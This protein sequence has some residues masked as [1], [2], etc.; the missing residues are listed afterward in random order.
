MSQIIQ[1]YTIVIIHKSPSNRISTNN[2]GLSKQAKV[3]DFMQTM[4]ASQSQNVGVHA[5]K[6]TIYISYSLHPKFCWKITSIWLISE[7]Q[8]PAF[9]GRSD[10]MLS[11]AKAPETPRFAPQILQRERFNFTSITSIWVSTFEIF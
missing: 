1:Q 4:M 2:H 3:E 9:L 11:N 10:P 8:I 7:L 5:S 6:I